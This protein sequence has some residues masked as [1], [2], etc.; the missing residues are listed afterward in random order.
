MLKT[1]VES[2]LVSYK[3]KL[4]EMKM[5]EASCNTLLHRVLRL[6]HRTEVM[7]CYGPLNSKINT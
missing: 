5:A 6:S 2:Q 3:E 7:W 4:L 1:H